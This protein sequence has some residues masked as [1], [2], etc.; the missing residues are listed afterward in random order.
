MKRIL[1]AILSLFALSIF[2]SAQAID[3]AVQAAVD[4]AVPAQYAGY[5][6]LS[7]LALMMLGRWIKALQNGKGIRGWFS[8]VWM[9]TN[10]PA[11]KILIASLCLL[12]LPSCLN[13]TTPEELAKRQRYQEI[14]NR[15]L[16]LLTT[17]GYVS[18]GEAA[19]IQEL[20]TLVINPT[21]LPL[22]ITAT[23][24]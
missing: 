12:I 5:T 24:K 11:A 13:P 1:L 18:K 2:A 22:P 20:G 10:T 16:V 8:A 21:P 17:T 6:S 4:A 9:G 3:P 14:G 15:A 23:G 19:E 7:I